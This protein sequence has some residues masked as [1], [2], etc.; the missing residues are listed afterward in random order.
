MEE[1]SYLISEKSIIHKLNGY[2]PILLISVFWLKAGCISK[3]LITYFIYESKR[4]V[5]ISRLEIT[6]LERTVT[7]VGPLVRFKTFLFSQFYL[8]EPECKSRP[9]EETRKDSRD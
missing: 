7:L 8:A 5:Y 6:T 4:D 3:R 1:I 2:I 9:R